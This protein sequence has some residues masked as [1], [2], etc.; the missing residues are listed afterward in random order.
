[1]KAIF[2]PSPTV[3]FFCHSRKCV[4]QNLFGKSIF[5]NDFH[6]YLFS[7]TLYIFN[8]CLTAVY[9]L[10]EP[11]VCIQKLV[12]DISSAAQSD[13]SIGQ[14]SYL[15]ITTSVIMNSCIFNLVFSAVFA[16]AFY[17]I[18]RVALEMY[19]TIFNFILIHSTDCQFMNTIYPLRCWTLEQIV[20]KFDSNLVTFQFIII[21]S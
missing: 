5:F 11:R 12:S 6:N 15:Y 7:F 1:M 18:R 10:P 2:P 16:S 9:C 20:I 21:M 3:S 17:V 13:L 4:L 19:L 14:I 8:C